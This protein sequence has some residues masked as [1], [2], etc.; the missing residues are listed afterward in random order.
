MI[1]QLYKKLWTRALSGL[2]WSGELKNK[3]KDG[4]YYWV[5][6]SVTPLFDEKS[7]IKGFTSIQSNITEQKSAEERAMRDSLTSLYN[8]TMFSEIVQIQ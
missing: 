3:R 6:I 5:S 4:T 7:K 1:L 2:V 8:R